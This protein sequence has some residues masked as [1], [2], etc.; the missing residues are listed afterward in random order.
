MSVSQGA[1]AVKQIIIFPLSLTYAT[2]ST[3]MGVLLYALM[4]SAKAGKFCRQSEDSIS[5]K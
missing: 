5:Y 4:S 2:L 3:T 1:F